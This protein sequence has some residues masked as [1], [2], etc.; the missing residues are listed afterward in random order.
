MDFRLIDP[1]KPVRLDLTLNGEDKGGLGIGLA[2]W[3]SPCTNLKLKPFSSSALMDLLLRPGAEQVGNLV[4]RISAKATDPEACLD[5]RQQDSVSQMLRVRVEN[6]R[7]NA[8]TVVS[9]IGSTRLKDNRVQV[10]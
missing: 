8:P 5:S 1:T 4:L 9:L 2:D 7:N 3:T 10:I 6:T